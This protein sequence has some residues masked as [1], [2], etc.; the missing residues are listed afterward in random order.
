MVGV[1]D[2]HDGPALVME[3][4][5]SVD[6]LLE[7]VST[8]GPV[9]WSSFSSSSSGMKETMRPFSAKTRRSGMGWRS[10]WRAV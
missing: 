10:P 9:T 8:L 4:D 5:V 2:G 1:A 7:M 6:G 3:G